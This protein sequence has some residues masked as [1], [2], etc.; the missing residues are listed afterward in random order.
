M[1]TATIIAGGF[2]LWGICIGIAKIGASASSAAMTAATAIFVALWFC[3]AAFNMWMGV[4]K[5]GYSFD[6]ELPIFLVIFLLPA[7]VA[8]VAKWKFF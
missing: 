8:V 6:E 1:R 4:A 3:A 7:L 5:A 2:V